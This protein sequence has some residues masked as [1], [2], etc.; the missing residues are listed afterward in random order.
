[1]QV[2]GRRHRS[3][4]M[5]P[6][7]KAPTFP[8]RLNSVI[9]WIHWLCFWG[10]GEPVEKG[11]LCLLQTALPSPSCSHLSCWRWPGPCCGGPVCLPFDYSSEEMRRPLGGAKV[12]GQESSSFSCIQEQKTLSREWKEHVFSDHF[13]LERF[14][15]SYNHYHFI[16]HHIL[17]KWVSIVVWL[18][19]DGDTVA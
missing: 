18:W 1:M 13:P 3:K 17:M 7:C 5:L 19:A 8:P 12:W 10:A 16:S 11:G 14:K 4:S 2:P 6:G 9:D 15:A